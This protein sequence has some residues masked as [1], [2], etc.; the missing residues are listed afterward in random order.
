VLLAVLVLVPVMGTATSF[1]QTAPNPTAI[2]PNSNVWTGYYYNN[3]D[4]AGS[5]VLTQQSQYLAF[6][7][8]YGSP[9][10]S[11][12]VDYFTATFNSYFYFYAGTYTFT[13]TS[14]D[15]VAL[16]VNGITYLDTRGQGESGK[17]YNVDISFPVAGMQQLTVYYREYTETAYVY[18]DWEY[19]KDGS[20]G[21]PPPP[22]PPT[23]PPSQCTPES[24]SSVQTEYG[25]YTPCIQQGLQQAACFQSNGAWNAP[26]M[27]SIQTEPQIQIWGN[28]EPD[29]ITTFPVSCDPDVPPE[30]YKCSKTGAGWFPN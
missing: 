1:G 10:P 9:G 20:G 13:A 15:E 17:T 5:P 29:S 11:V 18:V 7:W 12:P 27:G 24:A 3:Q 4:W 28:C 30:Q 22:P 19:A 14:D 16:I 2:A 26:N 8:G 6:N 21:T 23:T 25:D